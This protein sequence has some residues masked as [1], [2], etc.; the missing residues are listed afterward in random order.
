VELW[1]VLVFEAVRARGK[2]CFFVAGFFPRVTTEILNV[3]NVPC[4]EQWHTVE[5]IRIEHI[6]V[7]YSYLRVSHEKV[8]KGGQSHVGERD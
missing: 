5:V 8:H 4:N 3:D 7:N 2:K 6:Q 1:G